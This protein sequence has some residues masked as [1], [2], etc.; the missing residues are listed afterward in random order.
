MDSKLV[1]SKVIECAPVG[2]LS[3]YIKPY[4]ALLN[5]QGFTP[6]S[7][8]EQIRV[9]A[10]FSQSLQR[11]R[12]EIRDLDEAV[13]ER[14]LYHELRSS[15]GTRIGIARREREDLSLRCGRSFGICATK[16]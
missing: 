8:H 7:V 9:I 14:F 4:V 11:S 6:S 5:E 16:G 2:P 3:P 15:S 12:C 1:P 13:V 10:M